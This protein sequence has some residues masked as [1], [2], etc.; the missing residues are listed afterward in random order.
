MMFGFGLWYVRN[1]ER[2]CWY[3]GITQEKGRK[4]LISVD[5]Q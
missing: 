5:A 3:T 1:D 4:Q 2:L